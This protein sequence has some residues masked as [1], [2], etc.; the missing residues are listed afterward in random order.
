MLS[1]LKKDRKVNYRLAGRTR[2]TISLQVLYGD[3]RSSALLKNRQKKT[4]ADSFKNILHPIPNCISQPN[5]YLWLFKIIMIFKNVPSTYLLT[6]QSCMKQIS[7]CDYNY[8]WPYICI[9]CST[10]QFLGRFK[11]C[12]LHGFPSGRRIQSTKVSPPRLQTT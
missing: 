3:Q 12:F 5:K 6:W 4:I 7:S 11:T 1:C 10:I 2:Y 9:T 8:S